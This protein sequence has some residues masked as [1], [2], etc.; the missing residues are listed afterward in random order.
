MMLNKNQKTVL[1]VALGIIVLMG[2]FPPWIYGTN[3]TPLNSSGKIDGPTT[4]EESAA[5]YHFIFVPPTQTGGLGD[6]F[7]VSHTHR[8][9]YGRLF[10]EWIVVIVVAGGLIF[11]LKDSPKKQNQ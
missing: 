10:I 7:F 9:D 6:N 8:L 11:L 1:W 4:F 5:E 2:I 3:T